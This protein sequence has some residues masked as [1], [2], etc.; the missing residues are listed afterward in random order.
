MPRNYPLSPWDGLT[1]AHLLAVAVLVALILL[2]PGL[3]RAAMR[4]LSRKDL[5]R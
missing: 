1:G 3:C 2:A 4:T 5:H